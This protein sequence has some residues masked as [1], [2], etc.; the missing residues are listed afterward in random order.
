MKKQT[1]LLLTILLLGAFN[2]FSQKTY[3][4]NWESIDSRPIP[5][6][7]EDAKFGIFIHWGLY[8][9]PAYSPTARDNVS[10]Y[11][12]YA[13]WYWSRWVNPSKTQQFFIDY[14][15]RVYGKDF[16]YQNF[17]NLFKA[18]MFNPDE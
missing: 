4:P 5:A 18:E 12:R 13:E 9:V 11:E 16:K 10:T 1:L 17:V 6:W 14:H 8:S 15:N 2:G 7:F 3:Q